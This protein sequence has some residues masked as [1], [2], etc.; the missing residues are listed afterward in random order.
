M[1]IDINYTL[2]PCEKPDIEYLKEKYDGFNVTIPFKE[3]ITEFIDIFGQEAKETGSV[4][5]VTNNNGILTGRSTDGEG[6]ARDFMRV[7]SEDFC[8]K[9]VCILGTGG[10]A[11]AISYAIKK[12]NPKSLIYMSRKKKGENIFTYSQK[13]ILKNCQIVINATPVGMADNSCLLDEEDFH[14]DMYVYDLIYGRKTEFLKRGE[15]KGAGVSHGLGML[16]YQAVLSEEIWHN[17]KISEKI[18]ENIIGESKG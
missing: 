7:F 10:A 18:C 1:G 15:K 2:E 8:N 3:I 12:Q 16:V 13:E 4:N 5:T 9:N 11:K 6:F 14:K 17:I